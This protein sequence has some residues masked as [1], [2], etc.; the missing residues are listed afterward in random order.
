MSDN[1]K[2]NGRSD[3]VAPDNSAE[4]DSTRV[5]P[6]AAT[7]ETETADPSGR[8]RMSQADYGGSVQ[9]RG[10]TTA[11]A[12]DAAD[13]A[14]SKAQGGIVDGS[15]EAGGRTPVAERD[16]DYDPDGDRNKR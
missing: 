15:V 4:S 11:P 6:T 3:H 16:R 5:A 13:E 10:E 2:Q 1:G 14:G 8:D 9:H 12:L 7:G